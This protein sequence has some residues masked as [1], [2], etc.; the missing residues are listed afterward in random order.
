MAVARDMALRARAASRK[1]QTMT[2]DERVAMLNQ[3]A[4]ALVA[5]EQMVMEENAKVGS[6]C[7]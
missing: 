5:N 1:L 6:H 7:M 3:V 2:T 4:D